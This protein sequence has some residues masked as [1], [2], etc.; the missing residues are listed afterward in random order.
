MPLDDGTLASNPAFCA[1]LLFLSFFRFSE[2]IQTWEVTSCLVVIDIVVVP[3]VTN[4]DV[5]ATNIV[6][7]GTY[8]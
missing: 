3:N 8:S 4:E 1:F 7:V 5:V 2:S 6:F